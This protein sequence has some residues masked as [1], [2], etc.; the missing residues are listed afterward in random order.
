MKFARGPDKDLFRRLQAE[1]LP[2]VAD[3]APE[4]GHCASSV[5]QVRGDLAQHPAAGIQ[6]HPVKP[7]A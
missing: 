7:D 6:E 2:V 4:M 5:L 3:E 1:L